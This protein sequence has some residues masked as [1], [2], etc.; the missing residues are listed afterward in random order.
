MDYVKP[1]GALYNMMMRDIE[2][3]IALV[4]AMSLL[5]KR[6][7]LMIMATPNNQRY[8]EIANQYQVPLLFEAFCDR[9]Y[10]E[11][12]S[13]Q[14]RKENGAVFSDVEMIVNQAHS[15]IVNRQVMATSGE[16]LSIEPDTVCIHGDGELAVISAQKIRDGMS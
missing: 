12:G 13:L 5:G 14:P 8:I 2:I 10:T 6:V 9:A 1:H 15:L 3:Y 11:D 16:L 4:K 7:P